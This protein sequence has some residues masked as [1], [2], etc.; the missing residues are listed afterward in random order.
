MRHHDGQAGNNRFGDKS[1][2]MTA[3]RLAGR[4]LPGD[5]ARTLVY[6][7]LIYKPRVA[8]RRFTTTFYRMDHVYAVIEEFTRSY[9]GPFSILEFGV[10]DG[11]AFAKKAYATRYLGVEDA[12]A[13]TVPRTGARPGHAPRP[14]GPKHDQPDRLKR[15]QA[16]R[17]KHRQAARPRRP[18]RLR[19]RTVPASAR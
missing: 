9:K 17:P 2:L 7:A 3:L 12:V 18:G 8:L 14:H 13:A 11:Y 19:H 15:R 5:Y 6:R 4:A 16:P 1:L 10:A